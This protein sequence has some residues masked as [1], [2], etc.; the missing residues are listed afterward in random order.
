MIQ[1]LTHNGGNQVKK[2]HK[3]CP[4]KKLKNWNTVVKYRVIR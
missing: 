1:K 3:L 2:F 4:W